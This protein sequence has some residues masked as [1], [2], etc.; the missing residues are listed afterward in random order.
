VLHGRNETDL[1]K[2]GECP[3]DP[4]GYFIVKGTEKVGGGLKGLLICQQTRPPSVV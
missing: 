3:L 1:A 4:G 2:L